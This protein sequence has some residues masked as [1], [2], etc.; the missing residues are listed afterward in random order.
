M[1]RVGPPD[2]RTP[3]PWL[4]HV[5]GPVQSVRTHQS[6]LPAKKPSKLVRSQSGVFDRYM[7]APSRYKGVV[8]IPLERTGVNPDRSEYGQ[9]LFGLTAEYGRGG[10]VNILVKRTDINPNRIDRL[11]STLMGCFKQT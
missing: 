10:V 3:L 6:G 4:P 2:G 11:D 9:T 5:Q 8:E 7:P 1:T